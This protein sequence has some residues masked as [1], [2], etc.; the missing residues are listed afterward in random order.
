MVRHPRPGTWGVGVG[1]TEASVSSRWRQAGLCC[2]LTDLCCVGPQGHSSGCLTEGLKAA[3]E[4]QGH[5]S[6]YT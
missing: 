1:G 5:F 3:A 6:L 4:S 2:P